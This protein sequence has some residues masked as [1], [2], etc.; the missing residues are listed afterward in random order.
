MLVCKWLRKCVRCRL[1][2]LFKVISVK[3]HVNDFSA[4]EGVGAAHNSRDRQTEKGLRGR[5]RKN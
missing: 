5:A 4:Y 1:F 3:E 2:L